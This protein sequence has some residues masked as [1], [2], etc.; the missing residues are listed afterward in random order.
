VLQVTVEPVFQFYRLDLDGYRIEGEICTVLLAL[1]AWHA[2]LCLSEFQTAPVIRGGVADAAEG[3]VLIVGAQGSGVSTLLVHLAAEGFAVE[4]DQFV[5]L[6]GELATPIPKALRVGFGSLANL[7]PQACDIVRS[8]P[9]ID[10]WYGRPT[11]AVE[12]TAFGGHWRVRSRPVKYLI[13]L[14]P[15]HGGRSSL[16]NLLASRAFDSLQAHINL[17]SHAYVAALGWIKT[18]IANAECLE[19]RLGRL[20]DAT[21]VL[22]QF[23]LRH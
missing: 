20:D 1:H 4:G 5:V 14:S 16:R 15:N 8:C 13:V 3:H 12:P 6:E 19:L 2:R 7:T 18:L 22:G 11:F 17:P 9:S 23:L 10:D 21:A